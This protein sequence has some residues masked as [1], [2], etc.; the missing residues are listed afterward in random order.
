MTVRPSVRVVCDEGSPHTGTHART[1]AAAASTDRRQDG[2]M[3]GWMDGWVGECN[4]SVA[5]PRI[6]T[7]HTPFCSLSIYDAPYDRWCFRWS[8]SSN[9]RT[10]TIPDDDGNTA[11]CCS[12]TV[13]CI[14]RE[15]INQS[16]NQSINRHGTRKGC[17]QHRTDSVQRESSATAPLHAPSSRCYKTNA[18]TSRIFRSRRPAHP[19]SVTPA[20]AHQS[21]KSRFPKLLLSY[22]LLPVP[23]QEQECFQPLLLQV[24]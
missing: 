17:S 21:I 3:D 6:A 15:C 19:P 22:H 2:W 18:R 24:T 9:R 11:W 14:P 20:P 5:G 13:V 23:L 8:S 1:A 10:S 7:H 12:R 4:V 16:I